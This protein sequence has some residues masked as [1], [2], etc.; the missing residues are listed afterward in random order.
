MAVQWL[1]LPFNA[2][3]AGWIPS[4]ELGSRMPWSVGKN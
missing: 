2:R 1:S 3:G 4:Q